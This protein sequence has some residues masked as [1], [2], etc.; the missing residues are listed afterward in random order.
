VLHPYLV[1]LE[2]L[3]LS[4]SHIGRRQEELDRVLALAQRL[5]VD[6]RLAHVL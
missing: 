5:D 3:D 6:A 1:A 2:H 4:C